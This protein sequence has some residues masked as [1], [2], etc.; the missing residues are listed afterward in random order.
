L[1]STAAEEAFETA[2]TTDVVGIF[3]PG[4]KDRRV[5]VVPRF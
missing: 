2:Y 4:T 3:R 5:I 1:I